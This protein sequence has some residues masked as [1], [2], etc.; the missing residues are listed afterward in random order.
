MKPGDKVKV[1]QVVLVIDGR[2][3]EAAASTPPPTRA[4]G[5]RPNRRRPQA[6]P[7]ATRNPPP[8]RP[9][10]RETRATA[11]RPR[12]RRRTKRPSGD[13]PSSTPRTR[14][15]RSPRRGG[16]RAV[17]SIAGA[18]V[19]AAPSVR[20]YARELGVD[21]AARHRH[22]TRRPHRPGRRQGARQEPCVTGQRAPAAL[23]GAAAGLLEVGRRR[24]QADVE[25][26]AQDGR[27]PVASPGRRRT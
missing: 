9:D 12:R 15:A 24:G 16:E 22:R 21:I 11:A 6:E 4:G 8:Q 19:P 5:A 1:G 27:A 17:A 14:P 10:A 2:G 13:R 25:H 26:P 18:A 23:L 20:R 7:A 3:A